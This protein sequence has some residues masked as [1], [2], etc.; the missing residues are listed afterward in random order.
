M[1]ERY[2]ERYIEKA[3][4]AD[5][6]KKM[7]FIS[8]PRQSGKT[9]LALRLLREEMGEKAGQFYF[10]WDAA[11]DR[12]KIMRE[13]FPT[14]KG[15]LVLDEIHKFARWRQVV[16]GLFD[17]RKQELKIIVTGSGRLD[18]YRRGGDSLQGRYH[19]YRLYPFSLNEVADLRETPLSD[20]MRYSGFPE[21]FLSI[22][23]R[24][25]RR[26]SREYRTRILYD[27]LNSLETVRD[28]SLLEQLS[29]RLP[30]LVGSPLSVNALR[31]DLQISHQTAT[32][33]LEMLEN[34]YMIFRIHPFGP[35]KIRAV[36][37]EAKHY[38]F[39][40]TLVEDESARFENLIAVHLLKW[41]HFQQDS[42]GLDTEFRYFRS[43]EGKEV[44]FV[45][46]KNRVPVMFVECKLR[47]R[48]TGSAL[49]YLKKHFP[50]AE[51]VQVS[52]YGE[53]DLLTKDGIRLCPADTFLQELV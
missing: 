1:A 41:V 23:E 44:D 21:P 47:R 51:A 50:G 40:W 26:W 33:W 10:S 45:I 16:K 3:V 15:V 2:V 36:K 25:V 19:F 6:A 52:L 5:L 30:E 11:E 29:L 42:E 48:E 28:I 18:Y 20:L 12:E 53:N 38:H 32:R 27:E 24:E 31:E 13:K 35:P 9:T 39:D 22:S 7:V 46:L 37:K 8:G 34:V 17:K 4:K 43:R 14:G 49:R